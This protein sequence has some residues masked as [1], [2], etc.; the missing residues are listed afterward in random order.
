MGISA[1]SLA[2]WFGSLVGFLSDGLPLTGFKG[3]VLSMCDTAPLLK[4]D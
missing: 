3:E 2:D 1:F 4:S